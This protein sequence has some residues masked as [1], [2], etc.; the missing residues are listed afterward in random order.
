MTLNILGTLLVEHAGQRIVIDGTEFGLE[1]DGTR[2]LGDGDF[3][4]EA[5]HI[6]FD[7]ESRF[8]ILVESTLLEG[9]PTIYPAKPEEPSSVKI[10][11]D[12]LYAVE[13]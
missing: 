13:G 3:Q 5:L 1:E 2:N 7:P 11:S 8:K 10:I 12:D 6:Y 9:T 4:Y